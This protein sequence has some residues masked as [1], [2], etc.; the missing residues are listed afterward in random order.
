[1]VLE[2]P[3]ET[4][5][6]K[7]VHVSNRSLTIDGVTVPGVLSVEMAAMTAKSDGPELIIRIRA[8][9]V[10]WVRDELSTTDASDF[11]VR[12]WTSKPS[13]GSS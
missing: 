7:I 2:W 4:M 13:V 12:G 3:E 9:R 8:D 6:A 11:D 10:E 5:S 1:L